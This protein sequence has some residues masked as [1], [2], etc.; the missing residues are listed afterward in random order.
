MASTT[1][2][3]IKAVAR[4]LGV[5]RRP[6]PTAVALHAG[7]FVLAF[8]VGAFVILGITGAVWAW[9]VAVLCAI[10]WVALDVERRGR[11]AR[12]ST[13]QSDSATTER[14][15]IGPRPATLFAQ[16]LISEST[17]AKPLVTVIVTAHNEAR[18]LRDSLISIS[19]QTFPNFRCIVVDDGS[20]DSTLDVA[21]EFAR[22]DDRFSVLAS[23]VPH[24][25]SAARNAGITATTT[26]YLTF[27]DG[28]DVLL[29]QSLMARLCALTEDPLQGGTY[30]D[31]KSFDQD[32]DWRRHEDAIPAS[33]YAVDFISAGWDSPCIV[34]APLLRTDVARACSGFDETFGSAEDMNFFA[35]L[36]RGGFHLDYSQSIDV[37]Y[38]T[39]HGS[40]MFRTIDEH[41]ANVVRTADWRHERWTPWDGAP[42]PFRE[43]LD[44]YLR[45]NALFTRAVY[46]LALGVATHASSETVESLA[47]PLMALPREVRLRSA[48]KDVVH[49]RSRAA[50]QRLTPQT[51]P[52]NTAVAEL[53]A[54]VTTILRSDVGD[55]HVPALPEVEV[56]SADDHRYQPV[57][58]PTTQPILHAFSN[59]EPIFLVNA[60]VRYHVFEAG[61]LLLELRRRGINAQPFMLDGQPA[62]RNV[63]IDW[64]RFTD[65][66]YTGTIEDVRQ[67]TLIG[68]FMPNDW[69]EIG[70]T[71]V[72][73][74]T[75]CGGLSFAKVE[76]V[77]DYQDDDT[78]RIRLAYQRAHVILGQGENDVR[79]LPTKD[80]EIVG[81]SRLEDIWNQG[82]VGTRPRSALF[83]LNFTYGVLTDA[84][85]P[86]IESGVDACHAGGIDYVISSHAAHKLIPDN[87]R[88]AP[89]V[90][91][92][93]FRHL[94]TSTGVL[95]SRFST[96][97]FEAM[98]RGV[99]FIY[100]NPHHEKVPTFTQPDG[101]FEIVT[102]PDEL[103]PAI[104]RALSRTDNVR[105]TSAAFFLAQVD[106]R[107]DA[108]SAERA[109]TVIIDRLRA[110][111]LAA[112]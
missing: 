66:V 27:L 102:D 80:V 13:G 56:H 72:E 29:S 104:E 54:K 90:D 71:L 109:A 10:A 12:R 82:P 111:G 21:Y 68:A 15:R 106:V 91:P 78:G 26:P 45:A 89:Y 86:W 3:A 101:A 35:R 50:L 63:L 112:A 19:E 8:A 38:R 48:A 33:R 110:K 4:R 62:R 81:S 52:S 96:V 9:P 77:Q 17:R 58:V 51:P 32:E 57:V 11:R 65:R 53:T 88:I 103:L 28:D 60:D 105:Q 30:S 75:E 74:T 43:P 25:P 93:P 2:Q 6:S 7:S 98:A 39:K 46:N 42:M 49:N 55:I 85:Q 44:D 61:P 92:E 47:R 14:R 97:P 87:P 79:A 84:A 36:L 34:T 76:G 95:I 1:K 83:N 41:L 94:I 18:F 64:G 23:V 108:S 24:G 59:D 20:T 31:W 5:R 107:D 73:R 69:G 16:Q 22:S 99:P 37:L 70:Q 40:L 67:L 100:Y